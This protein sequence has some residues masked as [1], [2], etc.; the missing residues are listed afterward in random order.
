MIQTEKYLIEI[1]RERLDMPRLYE[2]CVTNNSGGLDIFVGTVRDH[3]EGRSVKAIE[4][5][6]YLEMAETVMRK[7]VEQSLI[8]WPLNRVAVQH[9]LGLLAL[10]EAS[11]IIAVSAA[12]RAEAF[13]ACRFVIEEIKKDLP[14]WKKEFFDDGAAVW[15]IKGI[16]P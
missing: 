9:R 11:V 12:H 14:I 1:T 15:K 13:D 10:K 2:F 8:R 16:S 4:Y 6:G 5:H 3:F 7:I